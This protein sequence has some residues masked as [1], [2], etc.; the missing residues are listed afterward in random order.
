MQAVTPEIAAGGRPTPAAPA[1]PRRARRSPPRRRRRARRRAAPRPTPL[2]PAPPPPPQPPRQRRARAR[3]RRRHRGPG[4]RAAGTAVPR[5]SAAGAPSRRRWPRSRC[6][7]PTRTR[8]RARRSRSASTPAAARA[9]WRW[10]ATS[11]D[12]RQLRS[13]RV[14]R[15]AGGLVDDRCRPRSTSCRS[16]SGGTY[17]QEVEIHLH[18]PRSPEAEAR[19]W[20]LA[21]VAHSK[22]HAID[23][24]AAPLRARHPAV[25]GARDQGQARARVRAAARRDF[26]VAVENKANAPVP[27]R[28]RRDRARRRAAASAST[29]RRVEIAAGRDGEDA[30][31]ACGRRSRS[32]SAARSSGASRSTPRPARRP[33]RR[34]ADAE[35]DEETRTAHGC[36]HARA[37]R[38]P[39]STG[40]ACTSRGSRAQRP[41]SARAA[42]RLPR[43][44]RSAAR[45]CA[46]RACRAQEPRLDQLKMPAAARPPPAAPAGPLLPTQAVFRQ[47]AWLPWWLAIVVPLLALLALLLFLLPAQERHGARGRRQAVGLR[48]RARASPRPASSSRRRS[49]RR[50]TRRPPAG[51]RARARPR[52]PARRPRRT[53]RSRSSS[54]SA[55]ARSP[56]PTSSAR[57]PPDAEKIAAR[58][59]ALARRRHAAAR[60]PQGQD[61]EPDPGRRRRSSRR[62]SPSTSSSSR[63]R[64]EGRQDGPAAAAGGGGGGGRRRRR[65]WRRRRRRHRGPADR[66][67]STTGAYAQKVGDLELAPV[68]QRRSSTPPRRARSSASTPSPAPKAEAGA[69]V[70]LLRLGRLP[71]GRLR[72]RQGRPARQR[73]QRQAARPDRQGLAGSRSDPT[74]SPDGERGRLHERRPGL[75]RATV[76][77]RTPTPVA[78]DPGGRA[79][80]R[81]RLGADDRRRTCSRCSSATAATTLADAKTSLCF[82]KIAADGMTPNCKRRRRPNVLGRKINWAPDGK[83]LL[84]C[85]V[86]PRRGQVRDGRAT[87]QEAVL[88]Q[89]RRLGAQG[90]SSPTRPARPGRARRRALARRQAARRRQPRR[91]RAAR[92]VRDQAGRLPAA[93]RQAARR[94]RVQGG[95][96]AGRRRSCVVVRGRRLP[97]VGDREPRAASRRRAERAAVAPARR[98]QPGRSSRSPWSRA[99]AAM[100]CPDCR[101]QVTARRRRSAAAAARRCR[102]PTRRSSSCSPAA[103]RVPL[104]E[105]VTIGRAPGVDAPAR[106]PDGVA[107]ARA[108]LGVGNGGRRGSRTPAPAT[109]RSSTATR[110]TGA[111]RRCATAR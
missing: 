7:C 33:T 16:A 19:V 68:E 41:A 24:A 32:G 59:R 85:G 108:D 6:A 107:H 94:D 30:D 56:C 50:S 70:T 22:A 35:A 95:L 51:T 61:R 58:G 57:R 110:L 55:T 53:P 2:P 84:V 83:T 96:A 99:R 88:H 49:R 82:G 17:E 10:S 4:R 37:G 71:A 69:T 74:F 45:S 8:S 38:S 13:C 26:D 1:E 79:L 93:R 23:A 43:G 31:D 12:R 48:G 77:K 52:R 100:L 60:R 75:P 46:G 15:A 28:C 86:K 5:R 47:K 29:R 40:R 72:Q 62:A 106:R 18:P 98:R 21:V 78:A 90:H 14:A 42:C 109:A 3:R 54:P 102:A 64:Q 81:P 105:D 80:H 27:S 103:T 73:L 111:G 67:S 104:V 36:G 66:G 34:A 9:C 89:P 87:S 91:E 63:R 65:R 44:R 92:A 11:R 20:E 101:R 39:A 25:R 97:R 76:D